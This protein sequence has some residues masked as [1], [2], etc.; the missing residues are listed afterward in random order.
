MDPIFTPEQEQRI[1]EIVVASMLGMASPTTNDFIF[2]TKEFRGANADL[3]EM[4]INEWLASLEV[5]DKP[6]VKVEKD[7]LSNMGLIKTLTVKTRKPTTGTASADNTP[8]G[9]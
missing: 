7:P 8:A 2:I 3:M 6:D 4:E 1:R 5:L 9:N